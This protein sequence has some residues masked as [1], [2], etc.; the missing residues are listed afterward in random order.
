MN[1]SRGTLEV[2]IEEQK[3]ENSKEQATIKNKGAHNA[4]P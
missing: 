2:L 1:R 4:E 3:S